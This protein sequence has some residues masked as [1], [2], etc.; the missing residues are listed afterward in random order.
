MRAS[1]VFNDVNLKSSAFENVALTDSTFHNV[2]MGNVS[3]SDANSEGMRIDG[4]LVTD[5]LAAYRKW[6]PS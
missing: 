5:L 2:C 3:I 1:S 4:I 6:G